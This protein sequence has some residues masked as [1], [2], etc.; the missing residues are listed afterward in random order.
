[1]IELDPSDRPTRAKESRFPTFA[2]AFVALSA[3]AGGAF[4]WWHS[5]RGSD[6]LW[7]ATQASEFAEVYRDLGIARLPASVELR[8]DTRSRLLRS[9]RAGRPQTS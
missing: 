5:M 1:M 9:S 3:I 7:H 4:Y 8:S 2:I 6:Y